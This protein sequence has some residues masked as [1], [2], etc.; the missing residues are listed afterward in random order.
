LEDNIK[1][2]IT[3]TEYGVVDWYHVVEGRNQRR[4][5]LSTVMNIWVP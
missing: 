4:I 5:I 2:N 3:E 1:M